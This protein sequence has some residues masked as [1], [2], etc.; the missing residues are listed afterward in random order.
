MSYQFD[1]QFLALPHAAM[2]PQ[3]L[4]QAQQHTLAALLAFLWPD[5]D[6]AAITAQVLELVHAARTRLKEAPHIQSPAQ[7]SER[8]IVLICYGDHI[9]SRDPHKPPLQALEEFCR[10][11]FE[12]E[13]FSQLTIHLLPIYESPYKDGGFDIADPFAVNPQMGTWDDVRA[14]SEHFQL[15]VDFVANHLSVASE[16]FTRYMQDDPLYRDFFIGFDDEEEVRYFEREHLPKIYRPRPHNPLI[17]VKKPDG[18]T[19]WVYMT[20]SD[21]QADVNY[22]NPFVFLKMTEVLLFYVLQGAQMVRLD[23]IPYL[24]KEWGTSCAHHPRT[25]AL[26][27]LFRFISDLVNPGVKLLAESMEPLADS[28]RY[29]S[30]PGHPK[31]HLAYNFVPCGLI[32]HTLMTSDASVFQHHLR[33]FLP[34]GEDVNWAVVCG[35]THDGSSINPCRAPKSTDGEAVLNEEQINAIARYYTEHGYQ[36]LEWRQSLA[37]DHPQHVR[38]DYV[39]QFSA[40][41]QEHPRFVNYKTITDEQGHSQQIVYEAISTYASLFDQQP[42]KIVAALGMA[43]AL[44]GIPF[45][46]LTSPFARLNDFRY[47]LETGNPRELNRGRVWLE[48]LMQELE[49][50]TTLPAQV[51]TAYTRLLRLRASLPALH[52]AGGLRPVACENRSV[53]AFLRLSVDQTQQILIVHNVSPGI[54]RVGLRFTE[55]LP[56]VPQSYRDLLS[57]AVFPV[58]HRTMSLELPPFG[59]RWLEGQCEG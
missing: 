57:A 3:P 23:A 14:I 17:P 40:H 4:S 27:E 10:Q 9:R 36:E 28:M 30:A 22:H 56:E 12:D 49:D 52:P 32:P 20:F 8:Q 43:L 1:S 33:H 47:Y 45:I 26:V 7:W 13:A 25:H 59:I 34:P 53:I 42:E 15:A 58:T 6:Q 31:A 41:H 39:K 16:W 51:F 46:Y 55:D 29:L 24:W 21:H 18:S 11:S 19:R 5:Q 37:P 2:T 35:V 50:E 38:A 44:P 48:E 54:Q